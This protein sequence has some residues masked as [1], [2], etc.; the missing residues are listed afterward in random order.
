[1]LDKNLIA[2]TVAD[3]INGTDVFIVD[4]SVSPQNAVVVEIDSSTAVDIDTCARITR[5]IEQAFDRDV[6]DYDLEVGSAGLTSPFKV[7]EQYEKNIGN[8]VEVL[9]R[10]GR[11]LRGTLVALA[12]DR[13]HFTIEVPVKVKEPGMKRPELRNQ[14]VDLAVDDCKYVKYSFNFK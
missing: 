12:P 5:A 2:R 11:K 7:P 8:E 10:D 9:T 4:I 1:M 3:A 14:S 13:C 6:E